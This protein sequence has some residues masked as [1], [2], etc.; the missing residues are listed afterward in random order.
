[1]KVRIL[2]DVCDLSGRHLAGEE[3][4]LADDVAGAY[5]E[6]GLAESLGPADPT[7]EAAVQAE[8]PEQATLPRARAR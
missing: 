7:P 1:M 5:V 2:T 8:M 6:A 3:L 4:D